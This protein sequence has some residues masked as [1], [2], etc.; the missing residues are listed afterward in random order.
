M[1]K[2]NHK[3]I[4]L[5]FILQL[6]VG[7]VWYAAAP[8]SLLP[9]DG[10]TASMGLKLF[11]AFATLVY[12]YFTA[13]LLVRLKWAS[14]FS[15]MLLVIGIWLFVVLPNFIFVSVHLGLSASDAFY[16]LSYGAINCLIAAFILPLW[17]SSRSIFKG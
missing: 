12:L 14:S 4:I 11:F 7:T 17:R 16:L 3:A 15:M 1:Y 5:I 6:L 2:I 9:V 13:W 10:V 8:M